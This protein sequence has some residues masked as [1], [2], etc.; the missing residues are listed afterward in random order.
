MLILQN[1]S[2][3]LWGPPL[4]ILI[5]GTG[6]FFT[7]K[8]KFIQIRGLTKGF[9]FLFSQEANDE[10]NGQISPFKALCT[11]LAATIGTG[12]VTG[13]A[14]AVFSGGAGAIFWMSFAAFL[15][16][17]VK[18]SEC[19]LGVKFRRTLSDKSVMGGPFYYIEKGLGKIGK[20]LC[21]IFAFLGVGA[22]LLGTGTMVQ[23]NAITSAIQVLLQ[24]NDKKIGIIAGILTCILAG[25][26]IIGGIK[27][28]GN[29][30]GVL[31]PIFASLY[32]LICIFILIVYYKNLVPSIL[33]IMKS[34]FN[35]KAIF[36]GTSGF[37]VY[38][39]I[40]YGVSRGIF[41]NEAGIGSEPM[42]AAVAKTDSPA[43]QGLIS[44]CGTFIDTIVICNLTGLVLIVTGSFQSGADG[45]AMTSLAF[46]KGLF[47]F[48]ALGRFVLCIGL[49]FFAFTSIIGWCFY[50]QCCAKF[51][52]DKK[53]VKIYNYLYTALIFVGCTSSLETV[54]LLADICNALMSLPN[55]IGVL[56]LTKIIERETKI[57][58]YQTQKQTC[59]KD[60][61][62]K[63]LSK[64]CCKTEKMSSLHKKDTA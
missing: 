2:R 36:G 64:G 44:M 52:G 22:A 33:L 57:W 25:F 8:L 24:N 27:R 41:S 14:T 54:Y 9:K 62:L 42:A 23:A 61:L 20:P 38:A 43:T 59:Q 3:L 56:S 58:T 10:G 48:P 30:S 29:V 19:L 39:S 28:I 45:T 16:M 31:V 7:L 13:V 6:L 40:R 26:V 15:G 21:Y 5:L 46:E 50:G 4:L 11:S 51:L 12:S 37:C 18:Y 17:A 34:A 53:A 32:V 47:F 60:S 55:L 35:F 1:I 63:R 49:L